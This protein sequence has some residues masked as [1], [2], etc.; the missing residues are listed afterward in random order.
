MTPLTEKHAQLLKSN[1][2]LLL[3]FE[4]LPIAGKLSAVALAL[5]IGVGS[6]I[7]ALT[8]TASSRVQLCIRNKSAL[9]CV[10]KAGKPY[11]M[12]EYHAE[13]W[14]ANPL[15]VV[16]KKI[17]ATNPHKAL[18]MALCGCS[19]WV[20]GVGARSLQNSERQ[21]ANYEAIVEKR[22][23]ASCQLNARTELL[24]DYRAMRIK[25]VQ[26]EGDVEATANDCAVVIKQC[27]VLGEADIRIAQMEAEEAIFEAETAGLPEDKKRE[28]VEFLR[29]QKNPFQLK[30]TGTQTF[31]GINDPGDKVESGSARV[32]EPNSNLEIARQVAARVLNSLAAINTSI[33]LAGPTRTGKTRTLHKWLRDTQARFPQ[34]EIYVIAQK[35]EDFP[36]V[37]RSRIMIF[38]PLLPE[39]SMRFLDEVYEKLQR[40]KSKPST[41][42]TYRNRPIKII[43]EDWFATYQCLVQK[44]NAQLWEDKAS[45]LGSIATV[46]GQYNVGYFICT[47][48]FNIASSGVA[49]SNIRLNLALLAQGLVR[50][51]SNGE[52]QGSYGVIEQML[53]NSN[54]IASKETR[55]KL[56]AKLSLLIPDSMAEQTPIVLS[57]IGNPVLGLM[58]QIEVNISWIDGGSEAPDN[59]FDSSSE[60]GNSAQKNQLSDAEYWERIYNL[61]FNLG[62]KKQSDSPT[63]DGTSSDSESDN[64]IESDEPE[65]LPYKLSGFV[66]TVRAVSQM[67]PNVAPE[68]LFSS[69]SDAALSG[70]NIRHIIK[71]V[72]KCGEKYDHPTRS[73]TRHGKSLLKWLIENYD[74][75]EIAQLPKIQEFL[76]SSTDAQ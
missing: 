39:E 4:R 67:F 55:D 28:Y 44:R 45:K 23:L 70:A 57:T 75:G 68:R 17:P 26:A 76:R 19:F 1:R 27:E 22:D 16:H 18:W 5:V 9:Q 21:L 42:E 59:I 6:G 41:E 29:N 2:A 63:E 50:T 20:A 56:T 48:T 74:N 52:E 7:T 69:V 40:R 25:E 3:T 51:T 47:Q 37:P 35:Y 24:E 12:T 30:L 66:W 54:V 58:P 14:K 11:I 15:V 33:F 8:G 36:G 10:D 60:T 32:I 72:L 49:D 46:G 31:D 34:A 64:E 38:D 53:N 43:L 71:S 62:D 13:K 61:E 73:Y 65:S